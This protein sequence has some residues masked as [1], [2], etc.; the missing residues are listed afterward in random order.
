[1]KIAISG[2]SGFIGT[3]L[4]KILIKKHEIIPIKQ[5]D[6]NNLE[7]LTSIIQKADIVINLAGLSINGRWT[8]RYKY[9]I[10]RSRISTTRSIVNAI[11]QANPRP[12]HL[13]STSAIGIY[14]NL[15]T[16]D[17]YN[18]SFNFSF[19]GKICRDWENSAL[20][21]ENFGTH[22]SI[23]RLGIVIGKS[24]GIVAKLSPFFKLGLGATIGKGNQPMSFI[25]INDL[26]QIYLHLIDNKIPSGIYNAVSP[27]HTTNK[28]LLNSFL[29]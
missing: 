20:D 5:N 19:L 6:I 4:K 26:I 23:L 9:E 11:K 10:Y 13:I 17:E 27:Q 29:K 14:N 28:N 16:H 15:R 25:H 1:M 22:V 24:G 2:S 12:K 18:Y 3:E 8:K 7:Y 21:A